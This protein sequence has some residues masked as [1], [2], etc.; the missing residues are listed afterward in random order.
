LGTQSTKLLTLQAARAV[1]ANL[2]VLQHLNQF[3]T[4]YAG[5]SIPLAQYGDFG[6][7]LFFVL[8]GF[9]MVAV[10]GRNVGSLQFLWRRATRIY[11]TYWLATLVTL[12]IAA[13][14]PGVVHKPI[15]SISMWHSFTLVPDTVVPVVGAG[16]T[17]IHEMYFYIVFAAILALRAPPLAAVIIWGGL[18]LGATIIWPPDYIIPSSILEVATSPLTFEFILGVIVGT[19]WLR[20]RTPHPY[21]TG[22]VG[23]VALLSAIP[24]HYYLI[25]KMGPIGESPNYTI[26]RVFLFG[27]PMALILYALVAYER[28]ASSRPPPQLLVAIGDWSYSIYLFHFMA[29]SAIARAVLFAFP[30]R[31]ALA[32]SILFI[33]GFVACNAIGAAVYFLFERP[34]LQMFRKKYFTRVTLRPLRD[35]ASGSASLRTQSN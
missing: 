35:T 29:L 33:A 20:G 32:S 5:G 26:W 4:R 21:I 8:S 14:I 16:W 24:I 15:E 11:P 19:L 34:T 17:L 7:D 31:G 12:G 2:V 3:E 10:A 25:A 9:V 30:D 27:I 18:I 1:A 22:F 23:I 6:V 13:A 28:Q